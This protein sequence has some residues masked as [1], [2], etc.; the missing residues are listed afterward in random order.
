PLH[1]EPWCKPTGLAAGELRLQLLRTD[2]TPRENLARIDPDRIGAAAD[3]HGTELLLGAR[4]I[5]L[6]LVLK[7]EQKLQRTA[8]SELFVQPPVDRRFHALGS[9]WM[10]AAT[11]G[12]V[13]RPQPLRRRPLLQ[14]QLA[15]IVENQQGERPVQDAAALM[16]PSLIQMPDLA[17]GFVHEDQRLG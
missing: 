1:H 17:V 6:R 13:Q 16:A 10:A 15:G 9:P 2:P 5:E 14:Q 8:Q 3:E 4:R 7:L 11:V 12:P